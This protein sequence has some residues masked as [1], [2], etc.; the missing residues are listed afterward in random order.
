MLWHNISIHKF[1]QLET[2]GLFFYF[3]LFTV[4]LPLMFIFLQKND[5][6]FSLVRSEM[7]WILT[8]LLQS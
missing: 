2:P 8:K 6:I 1:T 4:F 3:S 7:R 5:V